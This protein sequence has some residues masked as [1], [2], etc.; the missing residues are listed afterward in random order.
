MTSVRTSRLVRSRP[1]DVLDLLGFEGGDGVG[2][3]HAAIGDDTGF[4]DPEALAQ[5]LDDRQQQ[6]HVGGIA[7]HQEGGDWPIGVIEHDAE[8][9][10]LQVTAVVFGVAVLARLSPPAPSNHSVVVSK[11]AIDTAPN[12]G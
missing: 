3:D 5:T 4:K 10:L 12:N 8:H 7:G 2:A 1:E 9:D 6:R 11:N